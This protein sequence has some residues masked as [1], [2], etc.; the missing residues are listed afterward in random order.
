[1]SGNPE[2]ANNPPEENQIE[3]EKILDSEVKEN[4]E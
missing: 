4:L 2:I 3:D 1:M